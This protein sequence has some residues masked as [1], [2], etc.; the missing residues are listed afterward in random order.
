M[1][2][3]NNDVIKSY[4]PDI[5]RVIVFGIADYCTFRTDYIAILK[6][7]AIDYF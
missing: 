4:I 2:H 5:V 3:L 7:I 6:S 1:D